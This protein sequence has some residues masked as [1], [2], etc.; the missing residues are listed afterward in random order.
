MALAKK[1]GTNYKNIFNIIIEQDSKFSINNFKCISVYALLWLFHFDIKST[2]ITT[3]PLFPQ[4]K[5][6][7]SIFEKKL[8]LVN[9]S[10]QQTIANLVLKLS[11]AVALF[12]K[13]YDQ[14]QST[15]ANVEGVFDLYLT[16]YHEV[17]HKHKSVFALLKRRDDWKD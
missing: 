13:V 7:K 6:N 16:A 8:K 9:V 5:I 15:D 12:K 10:N 14:F 2:I 17:V 4:L 3:L 1:G 11:N